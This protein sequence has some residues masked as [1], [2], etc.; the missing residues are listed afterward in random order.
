MQLAASIP[1]HPPGPWFSRAA[2]VEPRVARP[3]EL[4]AP[5]VGRN[6]QGFVPW[7]I[8]CAKGSDA[9]TNIMIVESAMLYLQLLILLLIF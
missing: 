9:D 7:S 6:V 4:A 2:A 5:Q 1:S 8:G 3:R